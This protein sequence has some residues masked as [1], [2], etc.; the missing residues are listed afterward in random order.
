MSN[1]T[2]KPLYILAAALLAGCAELTVRRAVQMRKIQSE[3]EIINGRPTWILDRSSFEAWAAKR[4][5]RSAR[6]GGVQ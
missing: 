5:L 1:I 3:L 2:E 6:K 4:K